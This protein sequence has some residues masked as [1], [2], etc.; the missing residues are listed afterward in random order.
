MASIT[1]FN[2][3]FIGLLK[4][5][6]NPKPANFKFLH[7]SNGISLKKA[8]IKLS[9]F[10]IVFLF[11]LF[12]SSV[13]AQAV[14]DPNTVCKSQDLELVGATLSGDICTACTP[15]DPLSRILTLQINNTTGSTRTSFAFWGTLNVY[16][17][18]GSVTST[19]ITDCVGPVLS[20]SI[21]TITSSNTIN[22]L[23]GE[24][25]TISDLFLA[26]TDASTNDTRKCPLN[27]ATINPKCGKLPLIEVE[28]GVNATS[29]ITNVK[30]YGGNTGAINLTPFGGAGP[31]T[32]SWV[33]TNGGN[34]PIGQVTSEDLSG[35]IAGT[36]TVTIT[37]SKNC[38]A[39]KIINVTAP[40]SA[41]ALG[42]CSKTDATCAGGDGSVTAGTVSNAVGTVHYSWKNS[43]NV[44]VGTTA[45]VSSLPG[46][47]YN[48]M[49]SDDCFSRTCS[50]TV[51]QPSTPGAPTLSVVQPT[52]SNATATITVTSS[53]TG[54]LFSFDGGTYAAY[55]SGGF[56]T[57][58]T[59]NHTV[60]VQNTALC[61]S[62]NATASVDAQPSTPGAPTLSVVQPT[63][64]NATAT[65]T[66][67][68]S[69]TGLKFSFDG[70][71]YVAYPTGGYTVTTTGSHSIKAKTSAGC[72]SN[73]TTVTVTAAPPCGGPIFTYTQGFYHGT[74]KGC[75]PDNG[76]LQALQLMQL[77]LDNMDGIKGNNAGKLYLGKPGASFTALYSEASKLQ[78]IMPGGGK[79]SNLMGN[80]N[81][82]TNYPPLKNGTISNVLL[83]QTITLALNLNIPNNGLGAFILKDGYLT[84]MTKSGS[85]CNGPVATCENG[86]TMSSMKLT[87]NT[88]LMALL[89][90]KT[91]TD[92]FNIASAALG[93]TLPSGVSYSDISS[94][95]DVIN[96]SFDEGRYFVGYYPTQATCTASLIVS[97]PTQRIENPATVEAVNNISVSA[98]PN[99][100]TDKVKFSITSSVSGNAT[101]DL[102]NVM[103]VKLATVYQGYLSAG[104]NQVINYNAPPKFKGTIIYVL[105]VGN[106]QING[107]IV[108][109]R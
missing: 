50:V 91:V 85:S 28:A 27:P 12:F 53:T 24:R 1:L 77:S 76:S 52:C 102:Y 103:G 72:I 92:L 104:N 98:Y 99:P 42:T 51:N 34:V 70:G 107:K 18:D 45:T 19:A 32:Y 101:L 69:T 55:P 82:S 94:A 7:W 100:F 3:N 17:S 36:Y 54:L 106:Q 48:L 20:N 37:D 109:L 23:C 89:N 71:T 29:S 5:L 11:S 74:G 13:F 39:T 68:S 57:T 84:T 47:V 64:S 63:C 14:P 30:C 41:L 97:S 90:G 61:V 2:Q 93:G 59:G 43:S 79:A 67:T 58:S 8:G 6:N 87:N 78:L 108:E 62:G 73:A 46:G 49:V 22:Y 56:T 86:G 40:S 9:S 75:T 95:V 81:L 96:N 26:W 33:A 80:Y 38:K 31:Y 4:K 25:I 21:T 44:E 35:L 15:G 83:S 105:T 10:F 16:H 66:V 88:K 65:I 60:S